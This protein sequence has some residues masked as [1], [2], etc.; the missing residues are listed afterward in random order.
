MMVDMAMV[1]AWLM[2]TDSRFGKRPRAT[3]KQITAHAS[4]D[5]QG[6]TTTNSDDD[7]KDDL[8]PC[9]EDSLVDDAAVAATSGDNE[10][11]VRVESADVAPAAPQ[12]R[13]TTR[14]RLAGRAVEEESAILAVHHCD[15][16]SRFLLAGIHGGSVAQEEAPTEEAPP[17]TDIL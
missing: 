1:N 8:V 13:T 14:R 3:S 7:E 10:S 6:H 2:A 9:D 17:P 16:T 5:E 4:G 12:G 15:L 11:L